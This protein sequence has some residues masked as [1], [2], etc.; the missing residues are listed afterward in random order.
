MGARGRSA[1]IRERGSR[2]V[3]LLGTSGTRRAQARRGSASHACLVASPALTV[4]AHLLACRSW[5]ARR[6]CCTCSSASPSTSPRRSRRR[7]KLRNRIDHLR[8]LR[9]RGSNESGCS[10]RAK[11][12]LLPRRVT[13]DMCVWLCVRGTAS[14]RDRWRAPVRVVQRTSELCCGCFVFTL[15]C[16]ECGV[17]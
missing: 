1:G 9:A 11:Q 3:G 7:R 2:A 15:F 12:S 10:R 16:N 5:R 4:H 17:E 14:R 8:A 13:W 6:R